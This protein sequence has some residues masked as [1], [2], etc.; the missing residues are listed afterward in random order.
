MDLNYTRGYPLYYLR[1]SELV[2][3]LAEW[4]SDTSH[5]NWCWYR[6][7]ILQAQERGL[8]KVI[9]HTEDCPFWW[10]KFVDS[11]ELTEKA[12]TMIE[13]SKQKNIQEKI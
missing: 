8:A 6:D 4:N 2:E 11:I 10:R 13:K 12:I 3:Y 5:T 1:D 9:V 7:T